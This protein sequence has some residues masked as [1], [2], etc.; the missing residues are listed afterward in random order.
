M[1]YWGIYFSR[2]SDHNFVSISFRMKSK[3][4]SHA[5]EK[6]YFDFENF[7]RPLSAISLN[8]ILEHLNQASAFESYNIFINEIT[9]LK[10][11]HTRHNT[12]RFNKYKHRGSKW[13]TY[14]ILISIKKR[15]SLFNLIKKL[16]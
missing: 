6:N 5:I 11:L 3:R 9:T 14:C 10:D 12:V 16:Q 4:N 13:I 7:E 1:I 8:S 2:L 15:D